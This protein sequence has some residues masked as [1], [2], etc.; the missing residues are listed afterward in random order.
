MYALDLFNPVSEFAQ[1][2]KYANDTSLLVAQNAH[3]T[4]VLVAENSS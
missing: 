4:S 1:L 2:I 3:E